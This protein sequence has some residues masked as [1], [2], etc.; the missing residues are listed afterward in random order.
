MVDLPIQSS[1]RTLFQYRF[2]AACT[3]LFHLSFDGT[4]FCKACGEG[5]PYFC[6]KSLMNINQLPEVS[7][8]I[9]S[10]LSI[11]F[12]R[13]ELSLRIMLTKNVRH[14]KWSSASIGRAPSSKYVMDLAVLCGRL[15]MIR[16]IEIL[17]L[18]SCAIY[19]LLRT[20]VSN[21]FFVYSDNVTREFA[22]GG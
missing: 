5:S 3:V 2:T 9:Q 4:H 15:C 16:R 19:F 6:N 17:K 7:S 1:K 11:I 12:K 22:K 13:V 20:K 8:F 21:P 10:C 18:S 14:L